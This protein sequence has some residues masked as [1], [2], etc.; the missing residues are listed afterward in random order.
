MKRK[1]SR[2]AVIDC[3][4]V[5]SFARLREQ[6]GQSQFSERIDRPLA[7]WALASD[8]RLPLALIDRTAREI[9]AT[10]F[11]ELHDTPG[12]GPKKLTML[13]CL[14]ERVAQ[15]DVPAGENDW[16]VGENDWFANG[17]AHGNGR[18]AS[19]MSSTNASASLCGTSSYGGTGPADVSEAFWS[20]WRTTLTSHGLGN[21]SLGRFATSLQDLPRVL[22]R[23]PLRVY[24]A[25]SLAEIRS[26]K[27]H[28]EKRVGEVLAVF[29]NLHG[30]LS[31][32]EA[33][34]HLAARILPGFVARIESWFAER[35]GDR[36]SPTDFRQ[37]DV[38]SVTDLTSTELYESWV[39][40]LLEQLRID[41][42]EGVVQ[43]V[44][45]RLRPL[46]LSV[47]QTARRL[48]LTRGRVYETLADVETILS[49]RWPEGHSFT[50]ALADELKRQTADEDA[51]ALVDSARQVFFPT[52]QALSSTVPVL[53]CASNGERSHSR[54]GLDGQVS[55]GLRGNVSGGLRGRKNHR[56]GGVRSGGPYIA[57]PVAAADYA[58]CASP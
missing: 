8:R 31:R 19:P 27:A 16:P 17:T 14:L 23:T 42:G 11:D 54:G 37:V 24:A 30:I 15:S 33:C 5:A 50:D 9:L 48:G 51:L 55:G 53:G 22:W 28:G 46:E 2:S 45:C 47:Q 18:A 44:E 39:A 49:V 25:L 43:V 3:R 12:I 26:L 56:L 29:R 40:T 10:A 32:A 13:V 38:A 7:Y 57:V 41:G 36:Q 6:L 34:P 4:L 20:Q 1:S 35:T 52:R 58:G 21:E